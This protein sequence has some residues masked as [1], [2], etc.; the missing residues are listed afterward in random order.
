MDFKNGNP[1]DQ[2]FLFIIYYFKLSTQK[3]R[4]QFTRQK[5]WKQ[6]PDTKYYYP[7]VSRLLNF[8]QERGRVCSRWKIGQSIYQLIF[9][10]HRH[11]V[12]I[13]LTTG[14]T[15]IGYLSVVSL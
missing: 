2:F 7:E 10:C 15:Y 1:F 8:Y 6:T 9:S 14:V 5:I 12:L 3:W 13:I 4:T 11:L